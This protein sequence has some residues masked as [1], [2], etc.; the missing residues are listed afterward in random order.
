M[1]TKTLKKRGAVKSPLIISKSDL[2]I[3]DEFLN[4]KKSYVANQTYMNY[5]IYMRYFLNYFN[6]KISDITFDD[7]SNYIQYLRTIKKE[8]TVWYN[9]SILKNFFKFTKEMG[10]TTL[11]YGLIQH[12][13]KEEVVKPHIKESEYFEIDKYLKEKKDFISFKKRLIFKMLWETGCRLTEITHLTF[14]QLD[15]KNYDNALIT[16]RKRKQ[17]EIIIWSQETKRL[18][19]KYLKLKKE[20]E[21]ESDFVFKSF[22][23]E[24]PINSVSVDRWFK[25]IIQKL[26]FD[27]RLTPHSL[28]HGRAHLILKKTGRQIDV[29][30]ALGHSAITSSD[31]YLALDLNEQRRVKSNLI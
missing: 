29:K 15:L 14:Q 7:I 6:K 28:R 19:L 21:G 25:E 11:P 16:R 27:N 1:K 24:K 31:R 20:E 10:Y 12:S 30:V 5:K 22:T 9:V 4:H 8:S 26:E 3:V 2:K 17:K 18:L 23:L 13:R